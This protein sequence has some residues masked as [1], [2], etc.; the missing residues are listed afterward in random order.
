MAGII[1][2]LSVI[3]LGMDLGAGLYEARVVVPLRASGVPATLAAGHP[4][5][6]VAVDAGIHFWARPCA[7]PP[8]VVD[9]GVA[10]I[11]E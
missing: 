11:P 1:L 5:G 2:W 10:G 3:A 8:A 9:P 6:R 7:A 4:Y